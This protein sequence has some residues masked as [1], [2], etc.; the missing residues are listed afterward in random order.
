MRRL[1]LGDD[2]FDVRPHNLAEDFWFY[3]CPKGIEIYHEGH[4]PTTFVGTISWQYLRNALQR[5]N[6]GMK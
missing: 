1:V 2:G 3:E 5:K 6:A 4:E